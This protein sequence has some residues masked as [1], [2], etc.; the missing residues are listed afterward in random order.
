M[1]I[2]EKLFELGFKIY[3]WSVAKTE[4]EKARLRAEADQKYSAMFK[5]FEAGGE[6]DRT[7]AANDKAARDIL[8]ERFPPV[9]DESK[10]VVD[11]KDATDAEPKP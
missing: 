8:D 3:E 7:K 2:V 5:F 10:P 4:E 6:M 11:V 1:S 9:P